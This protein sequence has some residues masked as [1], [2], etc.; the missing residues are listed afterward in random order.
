MRNYRSSTLPFLSGVMEMEYQDAMQI[1]S[2]LSIFA[3]KRVFLRRA[4]TRLRHNELHATACNTLFVPFLSYASRIDREVYVILKSWRMEDGYLFV[5][6][7]A[8]TNAIVT[9]QLSIC[10]RGER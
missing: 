1:G 10:V 3:R 9:C 2:L 7:R 4:T 8:C 5:S 6:V